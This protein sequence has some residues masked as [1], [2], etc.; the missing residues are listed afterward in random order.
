QLAHGLE[1][2]VL[3]ESIETEAVWDLLPGL[4]LDGGQGYYISRP[5]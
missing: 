4:N 2:Q 3:G 5:Q 1:I